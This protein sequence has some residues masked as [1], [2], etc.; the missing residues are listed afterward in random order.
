MPQLKFRLAT[1][2]I[3]FFLSISTLTAPADTLP[4]YCGAVGAK[5]YTPPA[6]NIPTVVLN[7]G[8]VI[9]VTNATMAING[10][11][12]S[13]AAL[14][15][16][17]GPDG[18]SIQEA[19]I[20]TNND[21]GTWV[22]Q[23]DASL[24]GSTIVLDSAP[25]PEP[26]GLSFLSGG[27]VT[28]NGD[29]DGDGKPDITLTSTSGNSSIFIVS[30]GNTLNGLAIQN[31]GTVGCVSVRTPAASGGLGLPLASGA[32]FSN[33]T[34]S[35]L[36]MTNIAAQ[37]AGIAF[38]PNCGPTLT[39]PTGNTWDHVLITGNTIT[40]NAS[41]PGSGISVSIIG[42]DTL[43]DTIIANNQIDLPAPNAIA[44]GVGGGGG[45][46]ERNDQILHTLIANN[47]VQGKIAIGLGGNY[48]NVEFTENGNPAGGDGGSDN[49]M[50]GLQLIANQVSAV[51]GGIGVSVG[52]TPSD[53][54]QLPVIQYAE[55]N[56]LRNVGILANTIQGSGA[57]IGMYAASGT[58]RNDT[59][60]NLSILGNT[61]LTDPTNPPSPTPGVSL[62]AGG[63]FGAVAPATANSLSNVLIQSN[64]I[65][66]ST[67]PGNTGYG[68]GNYIEGAIGGAGIYVVTGMSAQGNQV[69]GISI[70]NNDVNTPSVGIAITGGYGPGSPADGGPT[71]SADNNV[72]SGTQ[73][74][75]NQVDQIPTFGVTPSSGI[76]GINVVS[77]LDDAS[78]NQ[79][80][81]AYVADNLVAGALGG[82]SVSAYLGS[83]GL[84]NTISTSGTPTP[85]ISLVANAEG[86]SPL[87]APNTWIEIKGVALAPNQ[88][89]LISRIW[90]TPDFL[91]NQLPLRLDGASVTVN[92]KGAYVYYVSPSQVNV[93]TPP[94]AMQGPV[95]VVVTNNGALSQTYVAQAQPVS[96]S[97]FVFDGTHIV[98]THAD[99]T[100]IG[101]ASLYPGL[102]TPAKP[103]ETIVIYANGFGPTSSPIVSGAVSQ[104][105]SL[106]P[107]PLITIGGIQA[108][109]RFAGLNV[110]PGEFQFNVDVPVNLP[111]GDQP[112]TATYSGGS[113]QAGAL[114]TVQH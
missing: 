91:N 44:I 93:L 64:T 74:F 51:S 75:C 28:I 7:R 61:L 78:G 109:I 101:P 25:P 57:G 92:G 50:D 19:I 59:I 38:C 103:G 14:M 66:N 10:D 4:A 96:P 97:F 56:I 49:L 112:I 98:A 27:Q 86:E 20:A 16:N 40:G 67:P 90:T 5:S 17:P 73:I 111:N 105:G 81:Q 42:G 1:G 15:A 62:Q 53:N 31:C 29:I 65:Q 36:V 18:I 43:Q 41:G 69:N 80:Q 107:M 83:G 55:N 52:D 87:I 47:V 45:I 8:T 2:A 39:A 48:S 58:A 85:A 22:I 102:T 46:G 60:S 79:V 34:I 88:D 82:A 32:T 72:V 21:P 108:N 71:L 11:T 24:K 100:D 30:G 110:T 23:F 104:S 84:G 63:S 37:G 26:T 99:G 113:T 33:I 68:G 114:L 77:G 6:V 89:A 70:A 12:S 95:N 13:V 94:D 76:K 3:P 9:T 106:S 35:N 54:F